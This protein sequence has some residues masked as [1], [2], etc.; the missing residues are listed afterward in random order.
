M[1]WKINVPLLIG[2]HGVRQTDSVMVFYLNFLSFAYA[3][4]VVV[5]QTLAYILIYPLTLF[6]MSKLLSF[7]MSL[8]L[9][10]FLSLAYSHIIKVLY[11]MHTS[12]GSSSKRKQMILWAVR[13][14]RV[15]Y[16]FMHRQ[17]MCIAN[18][19]VLE[20]KRIHLCVCCCSSSIYLAC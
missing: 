14:K 7:V 17:Y 4:S 1:F 18:T 19:D 5:S 3:Q 2:L 8:H 15:L 11:S 9:N 13:I 6:T 16:K 12:N 10:L 20:A